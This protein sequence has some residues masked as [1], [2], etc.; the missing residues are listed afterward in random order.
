MQSENS[1][2][3]EKGRASKESEEMNCRFNGIH[4]SRIRPGFCT[5]MNRYSKLRGFVKQAWEKLF[6]LVIESIMREQKNM[7]SK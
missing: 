4:R 2:I 3:Y 7:G 5:G 6:S 1:P